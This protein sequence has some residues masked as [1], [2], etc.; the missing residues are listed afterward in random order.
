MVIMNDV[1]PNRF[2]NVFTLKWMLFWCQIWPTLDPLIDAIS[3]ISSCHQQINQFL[4]WVSFKATHVMI[5]WGEHLKSL[6][7]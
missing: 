2:S 3:I 6:D 5:K 1:H 7:T 4:I